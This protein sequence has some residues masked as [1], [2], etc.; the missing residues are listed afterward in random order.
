ML[1]G[2]GK[3]IFFESECVWQVPVSNYSWEPESAVTLYLPAP[4]LYGAG[5]FPMAK[6]SVRLESMTELFIEEVAG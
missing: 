2:Y 3:S 6:Y 4:V 5:K 1:M